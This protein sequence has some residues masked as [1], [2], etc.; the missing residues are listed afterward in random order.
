MFFLIK[1]EM[2]RILMLSASEL[3]DTIVICNIL[4]TE[5]EYGTKCCRIYRY[6]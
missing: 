2:G 1:E 5:Y 3:I 6:A 4:G